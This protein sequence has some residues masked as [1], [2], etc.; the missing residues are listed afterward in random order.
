MSLNLRA[1]VSLVPDEILSRKK[2]LSE[3]SGRL[4]VVL[5]E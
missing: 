2:K 1:A 4:V 3:P 5:G